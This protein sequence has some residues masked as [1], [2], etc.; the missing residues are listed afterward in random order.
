M[1]TTR[2]SST[3]TRWVACVVAAVAV[4]LERHALLAAED[5]LAQLERGVDLRRRSVRAGR[6]ERQRA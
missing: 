1:P 4:G 3:A 6:P 2:P 5:A